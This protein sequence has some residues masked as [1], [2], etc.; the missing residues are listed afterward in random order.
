MNDLTLQMQHETL[1]LSYTYT[2]VFSTL[3]HRER[4]RVRGAAEGTEGRHSVAT[5]QHTVLTS[6]DRQNK[7]EICKTKIIRKM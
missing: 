3:F 2:P 7:V 6:V 1:P 4:E 5:R